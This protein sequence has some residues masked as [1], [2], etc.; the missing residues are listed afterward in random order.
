MFQFFLQLLFE[1]FLILRKTERDIE[2]EYRS[3][4]KAPIILVGFQRNLDF[5]YRFSKILKYEIS[6]ESVQL[7]PSRYMR[8]ERQTDATK[9]TVA[10]RNFVNAPKKRECKLLH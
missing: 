3:S 2:N 5:L 8:T 1:T 10:V 7:Q 9:L 4:S 6:L